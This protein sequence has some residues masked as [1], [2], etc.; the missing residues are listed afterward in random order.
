MYKNILLLAVSF[1]LTGAL[2]TGQIIITEPALP[3]ADQPVTITFNAVGTALE[4]Y[5]GEVYTHT[6]VTINGNQ[7]QNVIGSWGNNTTQPQFTNIG[8]DLFEL[9]LEPSIYEFY[10]VETTETITEIC[11]VIRSADASTQTNPDIFIDVFEDGLNVSISSPD[12]SPYFVDAGQSILVMADAIGSETMYLYVDN[13]L[14]NTV[15]GTSINQNITASNIIQSKHWIKVVA[16]AG[17]EQ[18]S[19][20]VYYYVRGTTEVAPL[21]PGVVDGINYIDDQTVTLVLHA[22]LK[23]SIFAGG[24]F[25]NW[26]VDPEFAMKRNTQDPNDLETRYWVTITGLNPGE[27]YA[28]IYLVDETIV[29]SDPYS[30]LI[31]DP[32]NDQY[33]PEENYPNLKPYPQQAT[34]LGLL[35]VIQTDQEDYNWQI[36]NFEAP[37]QTNLIIYELLIRDFIATQNYQTL[38]DTIHYLKTLGINAIEL[39]PVNEFSGNNSWGYNPNHYIALDKMYGTKNNFKGFIDICHENGIAVILDVVFNHATASSPYVKLYYD[40]DLNRPAAN[41]PFYNPVPKHDFNV[42]SDMNHESQAT[43]HYINN[44][45]KYW[46]QE[47]NVDGYRFDLSKGFTQNNT[48][49]NPGAMAQYDQSR[50][51]ILNEYANAA[52]SVNPDAYIILEHFADNDEEEV[53]SDDGMM[54]W[55]NSNYNYNE[56]TM[57]WHSGNNS[58]FSWVSHKTRGWSD[59]HLVGYMES[60]DE[61]R[62]MYKNISY[63]NASG[64]YNIQELTTALERQQLAA[65]FFLTIP[66]PKMIWQFGELGYDYSKFYDME[67]G[68]VIEGD[69]GVK[70]S[71]KPVRWDYYDDWRRKTLFDVY[72]ALTKLKKEETAFSTN[73]FS[74]SV[75]GAMKKVQL[76]HSSMNVTIVGNFDVVT[77]DINPTFQHTGWWYNYFAGDS[78]QVSD[79]NAELQLDAG[80]YRIYT[81]VKLEKPD[82]NLSVNEMETGYNYNLNVYPN[83]SDGVVNISF[84]V[85]EPSDVSVYVYDMYGRLVKILAE[86]ERFFHPEQLTWN[87]MDASST[88]VETGVYFCEVI[89]NGNRQVVKLMMN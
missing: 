26:Q 69:D 54:I 58:N 51:D 21:P 53:L 25:S 5:T 35:T 83:P 56:A 67:T 42:F 72:S 22:P 68:T 33:I 73:D 11:M 74:L 71:P 10:G 75:N 6:G 2:L 31:L 87:G 46:L 84:N 23:N 61:E 41:S 47:Y 3:V 48:L 44:V 1:L 80:E 64:W 70:V 79:V 60:H 66:G 32:W 82:I 19:D 17:A 40:Q 77:D 30:E 78:I 76:N 57:G 89:I 65:T 38:T 29:V 28:F 55:G 15:A 12:L 9:V 50:I 18:V 20:S 52:W 43:K 39:M 14:I 36:E 16:E 7:W 24:D 8:T 27:E 13:V 45:I 63:G 59:P 81:D 85:N 86:N 37:D 49:G 4:G 34:G 62:L 88:Q